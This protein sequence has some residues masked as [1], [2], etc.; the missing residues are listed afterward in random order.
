MHVGAICS[1]I[2][3]YGIFR[4][5]SR[6]RLRDALSEHF[7]YRTVSCRI[8]GAE[9]LGTASH[10]GRQDHPRRLFDVVCVLVER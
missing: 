5:K 10:Q 6:L 4:M 3:S 7:V 2:L 1:F 8:G 9:I